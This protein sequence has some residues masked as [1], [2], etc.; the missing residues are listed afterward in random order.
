[1][2]GHGI[3]HI[4]T[5]IAHQ[6][7]FTSFLLLSFAFSRR[8]IL[9]PSNKTLY[10]QD[11]TE[12]S[13]DRV[14]A[15]PSPVRA[16]VTIVSRNVSIN[17]K[18]S[19]ILP[20]NLRFNPSIYQRRTFYIFVLL[21]LNKTFYISVPWEE[22]KS[23]SFA[24]EHRGRNETSQQRLPVWRRWPWT[25]ELNRKGRVGKVAISSTETQADVGSYVNRKKYEPR[26]GSL[27]YFETLLTSPPSATIVGPRRS[28]D[29]LS[30]LLLFVFL[31]FYFTEY[32]NRNLTLPP[33]EE[34]NS[35]K[36]SI[37]SFSSSFIGLER[38]E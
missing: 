10:L 22:R 19:R 14:E 2:H 29:Y 5:P 12:I 32:Y 20:N 37:Q 36:I 16:L 3:A 6:S 15:L 30:L 25:V 26:C 21:S 11:R 34:L 35:I 38:R 7:V 17:I 31:L 13:K 8:R 33:I 24:S 18:Q 4:I 27:A 9:T 23:S 28:H 1:M